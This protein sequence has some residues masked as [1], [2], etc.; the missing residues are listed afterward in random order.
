MN[1]FFLFVLIFLIVLFIF[2]ILNMFIKNKKENFGV[3]C[4]SYNIDV[5][6]A[7]KSCNEDN[8]CKWVTYKDPTSKKVN[9][10]CTNTITS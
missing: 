1:N 7:Q 8:N 3:Y 5:N 10:W 9:S 6:T 4:G 2:S